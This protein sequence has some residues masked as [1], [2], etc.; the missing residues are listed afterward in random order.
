MYFVKGLV[1]MQTN[2]YFNTI[3]LHNIYRSKKSKYWIEEHCKKAMLL[4]VV[5]KMIEMLVF[6][7]LLLLCSWE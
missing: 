3:L 1:V 6:C 2:Q 5:M 7:K 4:T